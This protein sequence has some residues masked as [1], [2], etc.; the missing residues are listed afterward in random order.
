MVASENGK[1]ITTD[2]AIQTLNKAIHA[3]HCNPSKL[4]LR[5][6]IYLKRFTRFCSSLGISQSMSRA[7]T[8]YDNAPIE[9]YYNTLKAEEVYQHR[10]DT[11]DELYQAI[12]EFTY[13]WY[14]QIRPYSYNNYLIPLE[15]LLK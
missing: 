1:N 8:P 2:L 7:G 6:S 10:Y 4:I 9:W 12:N 11:I 15:K 13:V 3:Q 14:N 5:C